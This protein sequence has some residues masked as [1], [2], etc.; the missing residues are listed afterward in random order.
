MIISLCVVG[1][2]GVVVVV[3]VG[4]SVTGKIHHNIKH[5]LYIYNFVMLSLLVMR[6]RVCFRVCV[7]FTR[8]RNYV[9]T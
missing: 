6:V 8:A 7:R 5:R 9:R 3:V 1:G 2:F 4:G